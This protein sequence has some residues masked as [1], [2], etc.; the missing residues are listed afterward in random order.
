MQIDTAER[1]NLKLMER[2]DLNDKK[3]AEYNKMM[4]SRLD[5]R[6]D[7]TISKIERDTE[8]LKRDLE[9]AQN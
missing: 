3:I 7:F 9:A 1:N 6:D 2:L 8:R 5:E 4:M